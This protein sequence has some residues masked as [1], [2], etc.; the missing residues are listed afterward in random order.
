[1][2][3]GLRLSARLVSRAP[4]VGRAQ[5]VG[6]ACRHVVIPAERLRPKLA[7]YVRAPT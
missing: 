2:S 6:R 7:Q 1:M 4:L 3:A 5:L